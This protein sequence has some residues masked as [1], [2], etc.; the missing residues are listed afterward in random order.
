MDGGVCRA[1]CQLV[2]VNG[3]HLAECGYPGQSRKAHLWEATLS[4]QS[5]RVG[6]PAQPVRVFW[7]LFNSH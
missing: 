2:R 3:W 7:G 1:Y 5:G 4:L 6:P